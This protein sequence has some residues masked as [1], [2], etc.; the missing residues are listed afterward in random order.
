MPS[1]EPVASLPVD[2]LERHRLR[3]AVS[4]GP[5]L[6]TL[7]AEVAGAG[8]GSPAEWIAA[9]RAEL[10]P[11]DMAVLGPIGGRWGSFNPACVATFGSTE[12]A[13]DV[14]A[15]LERIATLPEE[16]LLEDLEFACGSPPPPPWDAV[17][18]RPRHWLVLYARALNRVWRGIREPWLAAS[19]LFD[20]EAERVETAADRGALRDLIAGL[21]HR[22]EVREGSWQLAS[23][24]PVDLGL[25]EGRFPITP[26]LAG[27]GSAR[28]QF[29]DSGLLQSLT[30]PLPGVTRL[31][32][33]ELL[34][35]A[36]ALE[37]LLG[38]QRA[39]ILRLLDQPQRPGRLAKAIFTTAGAA[40]HHLKALES[41]G[42]V[43]RERAGR[44]VAVHRTERGT[45][46][47]GLYD[48]R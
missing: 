8:R 25:P 3:V 31:L 34:P 45:A 9:A 17:A 15:E 39:R 18:R 5:S 33:G 47:L 32:S 41:A 43:V 23:D 35:P 46:L 6:F 11:S 29:S 1:Q 2:E 40:T 44:S 16:E 7:A 21:H 13:G 10:E 4:P 20:R 19:A 24:E 42:L 26:V 37:S 38:A 30:Y 36:A 22:A 27:P 28:A 48:G 12:P 14:A